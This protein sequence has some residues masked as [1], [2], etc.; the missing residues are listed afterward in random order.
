MLGVDDNS[1]KMPLLLAYS[2]VAQ[3]RAGRANQNPC[4]VVPLYEGLAID[5]S[6]RSYGDK[7]ILSSRNLPRL[8]GV[9]RCGDLLGAGLGTRVGRFDPP[10]LISLKCVSHGPRTQGRLLGCLLMGRGLLCTCADLP[11]A[12]LCSKIGHGGG[13]WKGER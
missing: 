12:A 6:T 4:E 8:C 3:P 5:R 7:Y 11:N 2:P 1:S 10:P 13:V 9:S